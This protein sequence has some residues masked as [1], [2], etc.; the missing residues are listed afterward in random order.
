MP[1]ACGFCHSRSQ[2]LSNRSG[3]AGAPATPAAGSG[4]TAQQRVSVTTG[5]GGRMSAPVG[6]A[7]GGASGLAASFGLSASQLSQVAATYGYVAFWIVA[8]AGV[9][10]YNKW[11]LTAWGFDYPITLTMWHMAFCSAVSAALVRARPRLA[12]AALRRRGRAWRGCLAEA[13]VLLR[14]LVTCACV[15]RRPGAHRRGGGR[16][17]DATDVRVQRAAH[18]CVAGAC[19]RR[20][21][22]HTPRAARL[23]AFQG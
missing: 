20:A 3:T 22:A 12:L 5:G 14:R 15:A 9:I 2:R 13:L 17:H 10:L 7:A 1:P 18:R 16:G 8:S 4:T 23:S 11:I 21:L 6:T 19:A